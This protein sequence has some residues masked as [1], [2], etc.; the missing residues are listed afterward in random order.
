MLTDAAIEGFL[1]RQLNNYDWLK[2]ESI[3]RL[4][5]ALK[6]L[7][8]QP[9]F[10]VPLWTHQKALFL[11]INEVKR[12]MLHVDM[13]GGKTSIVLNLIRYRKACG[14]APRVVVF[15]PYLTSV[16]TWIDQVE[17]H[18]PELKCVPLLGSSAQNLEALQGDGD[19]FVLCYQSA[20]AMVCEE[21]LMKG[22]IQW[23]LNAK[24]VRTYFKDFNWIIMDEVHKTKNVSSLTYKM[25]RAISAQCDWAIG[26][27]GTPFN[28]D[29]G[30]LWPQFY[31]IDFGE[32]L[33]PSLTF[34][35]SVF[36]DKKINYWGGFEYK[37]KKAL[38]DD[39]QK[40]IKHTSISYGITELHDMPD[41]NFLI[42][43]IRASQ[44]Q[45]TYAKVAL[46][47]IKQAHIDQGGVAKLEEIKSNYMKL[48]QLSSGFMTLKGDDDSKLQIGFDDNP[49]LDTLIELI[50]GMP[51]DCKMVVFHHF[52]YTN[53][54]ISERLTKLKIGHAR[55]WS[56]QRDPLGE[57]KRFKADKK[58]RVLVIN[59]K[60]GSSSLNLQFANYLVFFEQPDSSIDRQQAERRV[61]RPGQQRRVI[62]YDLFVDGT[63]DESIWNSNKKGENLLK[64]LLRKN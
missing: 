10:S 12:F 4:D 19:L 52:V 23:K 42:K 14:E 59:S 16:S 32:T 22:K 33:G 5:A 38:F 29:M 25:C 39:L 50:D 13:G 2:Q 43:R 63:Y 48:R 35:R 28:K 18:A 55:V 15:V 40:I 8:P 64:K 26:L 36:F 6:E 45:G 27:T 62:N 9:I 31:L 34:Y 37:L 57:L 41:R 58:C 51:P 7:D 61:W 20:V 46:K 44:N 53:K 11:L 1:R 54:L 3:D 24:D 60:M 49:K 56:G 21:V 17:E 30:E 47:A